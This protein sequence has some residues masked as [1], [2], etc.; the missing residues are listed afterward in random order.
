MRLVSKAED[1][2]FIFFYFLPHL[3]EEMIQFTAYKAEQKTVNDLRLLK[4][5]FKTLFPSSKLK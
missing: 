2:I 4:N 3:Y 1:G 5:I